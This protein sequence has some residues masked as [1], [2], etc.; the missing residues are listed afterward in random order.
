MHNSLQI[1]EYKTEFIIFS[2]TLHKLK[3]HILQVGT[4]FIGLSRTVKILVVTFDEGM[5][6]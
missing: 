2:T 6:L 4:N 1:N 5:T 3:K